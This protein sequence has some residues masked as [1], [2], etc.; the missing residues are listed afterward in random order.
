MSHICL[1]FTP[2]DHAFAHALAVQLDQRGLVI[3][4][5]PEQVR[6]ELPGI[7]PAVLP[8]PAD[9][10]EGASHALLIVSQAALASD[11][12]E[13]LWRQAQAAPAHLIVLPRDTSPLP[14]FL[15]DAPK[16]RFD[17]P[18]L[19]AFEDLVRRL[20]KSHAPTHPLTVESPPPVSSVDLL[21]IK[22]PAERCWREDRLRIN[23]NLPI[24]LDIQDLALRT[25]AFF[26]AC[27]LEV[28]RETHKMIRVKRARR[29]G[30]FDPRRTQHTITLRPRKGRVQVYYQMARI[31]V[32]HWFPAHYRVL[33]REAAALYRFLVTGTIAPDLFDPVRQQALR[34]R[35]TSWITLFG[36]LLAF[37]GLILLLVR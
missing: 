21:P 2:E 25:P 4:P 33:D 9:G 6:P 13:T 30:W 8:D 1:L 35:L 31:Q 32:W 16:V 29:Y 28:V 19:L 11:R 36:V 26:D 10:L 22:L 7:G 37:V 34:A 27:Q 18:F 17:G 5:V 14:D 15:S 20:D 23:Y 24:I 3:Y 12:V